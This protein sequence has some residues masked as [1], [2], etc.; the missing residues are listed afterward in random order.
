MKTTPLQEVKKILIQ[1]SRE[2]DALQ[3]ISETKTNGKVTNELKEIKDQLTIL[4]Q[5]RDEVKTE[6]EQ[7]KENLKSQ[8]SLVTSLTQSLAEKDNLIQLSCDSLVAINSQV[9]ELQQIADQKHSLEQEL[10]DI[11]EQLTAFKEL[12]KLTGKPDKTVNTNTIISSNSDKV[13]GAFKEFQ[14]VYERADRFT[15]LTKTGNPIISY[16]TREVDTFIKKNKVS[17]VQDLESY[18]KANGFLRG[19]RSVKTQD[20]ATSIST[21]SGLFLETLS[22]YLRVNNKSLFTFWQFPTVQFDHAR[23][24]GDTIDI[25]RAAYL[26]TASDPDDRLLSGGGTFADIDATSQAIQTGIV[27][28]TLQEWGLGK[29]SSYPPVGIPEFVRAYSMMDLLRVLNR[30]LQYDYHHWEDL[31]IRSLWS[32][33]SRVVYNNN[34]S[35]TTDPTAVT[36]AGSGTLTRGFLDKLCAEMASASIPAYM[37]GCYG[38]VVPPIPLSNLKSSL[39][40]LFNPATPQDLM[41]LTNVLNPTTINIGETEK[42]TGYIGKYCGFH[43]FSSNA[44]GVGS[45]GTEG[46]QTETLGTTARTTRTGY[47]FGAETIGRGVGTP[48]QLVDEGTVR[49]GRMG[50]YIWRSEESFVA[51]DVDP[52]GYSDT[53]AVPQQLRVFEI[54]TTDT[55]TA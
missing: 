55:P 39:G 3:A 53:S 48:F 12:H 40:N 8:D 44:F 34:D 19:T 52:T 49:F 54:H 27:K 26:N 9:Q 47:A 43:I 21:L 45:V 14:E 5:E 6:L 7:T 29:N 11:K 50:R 33:T 25:P 23:G 15:K 42:I 28:A 16:D 2:L 35:V 4:N 41:D 22:A 10:T 30:N 31:K 20:A 46:V 1:E 37:D 51:L 38:L 36:V 13:Q 18:A 24:E 17:L 32:P